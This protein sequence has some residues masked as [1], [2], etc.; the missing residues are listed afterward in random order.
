LEQVVDG[1]GSGLTYAGLGQYTAGFFAGAQAG[2]LPL[3]PLLDQ[4]IENRRL[5]GIYY[6]GQWVDVGTP[7]RLAALDDQVRQQ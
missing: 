3:R 6:P 1:A 5:H 4:A 2:K 7:Q